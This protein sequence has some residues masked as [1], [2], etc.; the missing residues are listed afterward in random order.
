MQNSA[1]FHHNLL[2]RTL[3]VR[4]APDRLAVYQRAYGVRSFQASLAKNN[5][6]NDF[7]R[8]SL[9]T[10]RDTPSAAVAAPKRA[11]AQ[12]AAA[13]FTDHIFGG[14]DMEEQAVTEAARNTEKRI[15]LHGLLP[16]DGLAEVDTAVRIKQ[17]ALLQEI[18]SGKRVIR[19][20]AFASEFLRNTPYVHIRGGDSWGNS[21]KK[22][23]KLASDHIKGVV[24]S[25][26][27]KY[28]VLP[29]KLRKR[30]V[31]TFVP[32]VMYHVF[33][34]M[35]VREQGETVRFAPKA[36]PNAFRAV[37]GAA[38][39]AAETDAGDYDA[40]ARAAVETML[41]NEPHQDP[42][43]Y[44]QVY[45][46]GVAGDD[47]ELFDIVTDIKG[48]FT[49]KPATKDGDG[50]LANVT[51]AHPISYTLRCMIEYCEETDLDVITADVMSLSKLN[52]PNLVID[53]DINTAMSGAIRAASSLL[54][55]TLKVTLQRAEREHQKRV[56]DMCLN[57]NLEP[58][59]SREA[60]A[61]DWVGSTADAVLMPTKTGE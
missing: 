22:A 30:M 16:S 18:L 53:G 2:A 28:S 40:A 54:R 13:L 60:A 45:N 59:A 56:F 55:D 42:E 8:R 12:Q 26:L 33:T 29:P 37:L 7:T 35:I 36:N 19:V 23:E 48:A 3:R 34:R 43:L 57:A 47:G 38:A 58:I 9:M 21:N 39:I 1:S 27:L 41:E 44:Q 46:E 10:A 49:S 50:S 20:D 52:I 17:M 11:A 25:S 5:G 51:R 24:L 32:T 15:K 4:N 14:P 31:E 61:L 6:H